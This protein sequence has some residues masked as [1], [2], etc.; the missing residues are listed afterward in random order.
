MSVKIHLSEILGKKKMRVSELAG[1]SGISRYALHFIYHEETR[2][3]S[4]EVLEKL[5]QTLGVSVGELLEYVPDE[6]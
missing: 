4:F 6:D 2:S 3:I 1:Q 5:C